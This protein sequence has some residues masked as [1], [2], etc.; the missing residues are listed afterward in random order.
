MRFH[1]RRRSK[2]RD[3]R[4]W[5]GRKVG[6]VLAG[7]YLPELGDRVKGRDV[8]LSWFDAEPLMTFTA[9]MTSMF[10]SIPIPIE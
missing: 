8:D 5:I 6:E 10:D 4:E 9:I 7:V 1:Q 3:G 2:L